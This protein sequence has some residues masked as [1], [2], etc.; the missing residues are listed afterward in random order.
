MF[1]DFALEMSKLMPD[2]G[3]FVLDD[4]IFYSKDFDDYS[5]IKR[6]EACNAKR[7]SNCKVQY[8]RDSFW[9]Q[10]LLEVSS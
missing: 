7:N 4:T 3:N 9:P 8:M 1:Q 6:K 2:V 5:S 10:G